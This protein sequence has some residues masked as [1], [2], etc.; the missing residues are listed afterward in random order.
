MEIKNEIIEQNPVVSNEFKSKNGIDDFNKE[1]IKFNSH[2]GNI[3]YI[4]LNDINLK[5]ISNKEN[6]FNMDEI[7]DLD[8]KNENNDS[9]AQ[10]VRNK[11]GTYSMKNIYSV[12]NIQKKL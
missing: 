11:K 6:N 2:K 4:N 1:I 3:N 9:K 7:I 5:E 12:D 10:S 8:C